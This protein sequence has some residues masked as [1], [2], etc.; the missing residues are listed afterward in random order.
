MDEVGPAQVGLTDSNADE[1]RKSVLYPVYFSGGNIEWY[2]GYHRLP[3]GGDMR[4]ENFRTREQ[5]YRYMRYA[6]TFMQQ[7]LPFWE[8]EPNDNALSGGNDRDQVFAKPGEVYAVYLQNG[9]AG[10]RLRVVEGDYQF[11]WFDPRNGQFVGEPRTVSGTNIAIGA[12]PTATAQDWVVL[13]ASASLP[14]MGELEPAMVEPVPDGVEPEPAT[15]PEPSDE[16]A[17]SVA[18][19]DAPTC[20]NGSAP[21]QV[22]DTPTADNAE[23][24]A[25]QENGPTAIDET[26]APAVVEAPE[27]GEPSSVAPN[28]V[29]QTD[30]EAASTEPNSIDVTDSTSDEVP[31]STDNPMVVVPAATTTDNVAPAVDVNTQN[32]NA[33]DTQPVDEMAAPAATQSPAAANP[34]TSSG[35]G[36]GSSGFGLWLMLGWACFA[37]S[38]R[39]ISRLQSGRRCGLPR[40]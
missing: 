22:S 32:A 25:T 21:A 23:N 13:I 31:E 18:L 7:H 12:A 14:A 8:M 5:M 6:R 39:T 38:S 17:A 27:N 1:L 37:R 34:T 33:P 9:R 28:G 36:S 40:G 4:T 35:G 3:L 29:E 26:M 19:I 2:F 16:Q 24:C 15:N 10:K 30:G 11:S 20:D